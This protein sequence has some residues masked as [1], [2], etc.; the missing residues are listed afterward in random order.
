[1]IEG[2]EALGV[3]DEI[4]VVNN[5]AERGTSEEVA[6]TNA[7]EVFEQRQGYGASIRKG[8]ASTDADLVSVVEPDG[9]FD[10][11]DVVKLLTYSDD[12][13][14]VFGSRTIR[15]LI[16]T[17]ANMGTFLRWGNWAG[18]KLMEVLFNSN[19]LSDVGCTLRVVDGP[20]VRAMLPHFTVDGGAFGPEMMLLALIGRWRVIQ[21]PVNYRARAGHAG[22]TES[23]VK[24]VGIGLGM[25]RLIGRYRTRSTAVRQALESTGAVRTDLEDAP[26]PGGE[27]QHMIRRSP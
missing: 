6:L 15:D 3:V 24:A 27:P 25:I 2:L 19:S 11:H 13:N 21:L 20:A 4:V 7:R 23:F 9:T 18:A 16:W 8:I 14:F 10:P 26:H 17:G 12:F 5:N 22:T 1:V